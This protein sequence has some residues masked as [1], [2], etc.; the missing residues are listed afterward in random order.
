MKIKEIDNDNDHREQL[1]KTGFWGHRGAGC[2]FQALDSGKICIA[3]RSDYVEQPG[4]WGTWGGA[5]DGNESPETAARR[6]VRE[7]AGYNG[8]MKLLPMYVFKHSSGFT[9]YNF[10]ALV[11][12]E[13]TPKLDWESQGYAWVEYGDWPTP[14]HPGLKLLLADPASISLLQKYSK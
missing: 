7:E 5:I 9:Y 14:L 3:H 1:K 8:K 13:F 6:E 12:S 11:D 2:L 4:T 10:L